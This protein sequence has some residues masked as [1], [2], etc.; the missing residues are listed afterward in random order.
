MSSGGIIYLYHDG[1]TLV[2][3]LSRSLFAMSTKKENDDPNPASSKKY[4]LSLSRMRK[5]RFSSVSE[6]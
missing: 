4:K 6:H 3:M 1:T 2:H 5:G